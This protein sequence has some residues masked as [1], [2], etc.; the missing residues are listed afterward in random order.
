MKETNVKITTD[1]KIFNNIRYTIA[2]T[3]IVL[4]LYLSIFLSSLWCFAPLLLGYAE[5]TTY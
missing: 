5:N 4:S 3:C 2:L 1:N